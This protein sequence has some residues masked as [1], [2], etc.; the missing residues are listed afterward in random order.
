MRP[1]ALVQEIVRACRAQKVSSGIIAV[2]TAAMCLVTIM[3][4]GRSTIAAQSI[5]DHLNSPAARSIVISR[6]ANVPAFDSRAL[7]GIGSL[8]DV[9]AAVGIDTAK[10]MFNGAIGSGGPPIPIRGISGQWSQS[11][12]IES[13]REPREGEIVLPADL[14]VEAGFA[15]GYGYLV[16]RDG[17]DFPV[18]GT[19]SSTGLLPDLEKTGLIVSEGAYVDR[20]HVLAGSVDAVDRVHPR[21]RA[22]IVGAQYED[23]LFELPDDVR[24]VAAG[25][26]AEFGEYSASLLLAILALGGMLIAATV[27]AGVLSRAAD[28]GRRRVL[29][30]SR[31]LL[32]LIVTGSSVIPALGG[33]V[34]GAGIGIAAVARGGAVPDWEF[35]AAIIVLAVLASVL[36][37]IPPAVYSA[38]RDPVLVLRH[39]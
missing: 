22:L 14:M 13:G 15:D 20:I 31:T 10:D 21:G 38:Y 37:S 35:T 39:G 3:T 26:K 6:T 33:A 1:L 18:V 9:Q 29:G 27:F 7:R 4:L 17:R 36:A 5:E 11:I 8:S 16:D 32:T 34:V 30:A 28:L 12:V 24:D 25:I 19:F 2:L 23:T